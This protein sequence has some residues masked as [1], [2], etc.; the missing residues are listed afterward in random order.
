ML[1]KSHS[2]REIGHSSRE[3]GH[4][5]REKSHSS[6]EKSHSCAW[7]ILILLTSRTPK[8]KIKTFKKTRKGIFRKS[9]D[10]SFRARLFFEKRVTKGHFLN[11]L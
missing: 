4:S 10:N 8:N 6:R 9:V 2:S 5:S 1:N 11:L 3:I 7:K